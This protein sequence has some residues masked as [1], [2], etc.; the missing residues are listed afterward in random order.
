[1]A[2][3]NRLD[4]FNMSGNSFAVVISFYDGVINQLIAWASFGGLPNFHIGIFS[5]IW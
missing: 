3:E 2:Q 1:M 4:L 5:V